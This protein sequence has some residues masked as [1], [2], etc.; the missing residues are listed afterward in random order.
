MKNFCFVYFVDS[1][2][3]IWC[4]LPWYKRLSFFF[5]WQVTFE[6][7]LFV[8]KWL[9]KGLGFFVKAINKNFADKIIRMFC[10]L[11][12]NNM[13]WQVT[14]SM[15]LFLIRLSS[16]SNGFTWNFEHC[17]LGDSFARAFPR[18]PLPDTCVGAQLQCNR[19]IKPLALHYMSAASLYHNCLHNL[20]HWNFEISHPGESTR[21][22]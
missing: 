6:G 17:T 3:T 22:S 7:L 15:F 18:I 20:Y 13:F 9:L 21:F 4:F 5:C 2:Q 8:D 16:G 14:K 10:T 19:K 12:A 1:E 11:A